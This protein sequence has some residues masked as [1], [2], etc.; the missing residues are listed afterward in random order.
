MDCIAYQASLSMEFPRQV[1]WSGLPFP[2]PGDSPDPVIKP[3]SPALQ[4]GFLGD[5]AAL[6]V[7]SHTFQNSLK[8]YMI[9][10]FI[11]ILLTREPLFQIKLFQDQVGDKMTL[12]S[13]VYVYQDGESI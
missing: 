1:Y 11:I 13:S 5:S 6:C 8:N 12:C 2:S 9:G 10:S 4:A 7:K 3:T